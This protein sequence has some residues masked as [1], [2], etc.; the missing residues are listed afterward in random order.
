MNSGDQQRILGYICN[1][2]SKRVLEYLMAHTWTGPAG[3]G[4]IRLP[5][6][7]SSFISVSGQ[8]DIDKTNRY[9]PWHALSKG[10]R[11]MKLRKHEQRIPALGYLQL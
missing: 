2:N 9:T 3:G 5:I 11:L 1:A 10:F 8:K 6:G 4:Y 7:N